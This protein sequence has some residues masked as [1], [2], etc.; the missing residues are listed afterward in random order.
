MTLQHLPQDTLALC[1]VAELLRA[2]GAS[3]IFHHPMVE[4]R[5][6]RFERHR[7]AGAVD[8]G[9]DVVRE[10]LHHIEVAQ[11]R[12]LVRKVGGE[13]GCCGAVRAPLASPGITPAGVAPLCHHGM[14]HRIG[15]AQRQQRRALVD[16]VADV[17]RAEAARKRT[18]Q[19]ASQASTD[20]G[21]GGTAPRSSSPGIAP[22]S[23]AMRSIQ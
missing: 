18:E 7:H 16:L 14:V 22:V 17:G 1:G 5:H 20:R 11:T 10:I 13:A 4:Q 6:A 12:D 2:A 21:L 8:L 15:V 23:F 9:Q 19:P 3:R